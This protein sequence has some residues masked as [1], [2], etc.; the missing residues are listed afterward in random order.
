MACARNDCLKLP[1]ATYFEL[2]FQKLTKF[3]HVL[4]NIHIHFLHWACFADLSPFGC[5][6]RHNDSFIFSI[7][8][9]WP[10][11]AAEK[12]E[13]KT[14]WQDVSFLV[15]APIPVWKPEL[16]TFLFILTLL[17]QI[18]VSS[19]LFTVQDTVQKALAESINLQLTGNAQLSAHL[20]SKIWVKSAVGDCQVWA[21]HFL[22]TC[23]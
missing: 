3:W 6:V 8:Y 21:L 14:E 4:C 16:L 2:F 15:N 12:F 7:S 11:P 19:W 10:G 17:R 1:S 23:A 20:L 9:H 22:D 13:N 5:R 18:A